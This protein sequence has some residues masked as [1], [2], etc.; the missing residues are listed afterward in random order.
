VA[1]LKDRY[2]GTFSDGTPRV[3]IWQD[4]DRAFSSWSRQLPTFIGEP[5]TASR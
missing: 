5:K 2:V 1:V 4:A 3:G